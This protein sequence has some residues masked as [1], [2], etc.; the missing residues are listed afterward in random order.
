MKSKVPPA[1]PLPVPTLLQRAPRREDPAPSH[2]QAARSSS[3]SSSLINSAL[4]SLRPEARLPSS[5][6]MQTKPSPGEK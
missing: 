3:V 5:V 1:G 6:R 2:R 4:T